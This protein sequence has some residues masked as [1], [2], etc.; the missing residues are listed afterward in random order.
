MLQEYINNI[1]LPIEDDASLTKLKKISS[2][3]ARK[4]KKNKEK[5]LNFTLAALDP[6]ICPENLHI[7]EVEKLITGKW[8]T[9]IVNSKDSP[10]TFIRA[11]MLEALEIVSEDINFAS[12]I[13]LAGRNI[14]KHFELFGK[15]KEI[16][17]NFLLTIGKTIEQKAS[18]N[19]S[20]FIAEDV[21]TLKVSIDG[22]DGEIIDEDDT[23]DLTLEQVNLA[24]SNMT[25]QINESTTQI[26]D[27]INIVLRDIISKTKEKNTL[28]EMRSRLLWWKESSYSPSLESSYRDM[29]DSVLQVIIALD[30]SKFV[31]ILY[32]TSA[33]YFLKE[34][35]LGFKKDGT[36]KISEF[37]SEV[38]ENQ[39]TLKTYFN[40]FSD[41]TGRI[42]LLNF[43]TGI[44]NNRYEISQFK[45]LVGFSENIE[46]TFSELTLW[47]FHDLQVGKFLK[48]K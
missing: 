18:L 48:N 24:L 47:V 9:F 7:K 46:I 29:E 16:I 42:T 36:L 30:Y 15:E 8:N 14:Q 12:L 34:T 11:V 27:R 3:L 21:D 44:I 13:W 45:N 40:D 41:K 35:L 10:I 26:Q 17:Q 25:V 39:S 22:I 20:S 4:L 37:L 23:T 2:E 33:E 1:L 6:E 43:I 38:K 32:P 31:P 19:W 5:T 28:L